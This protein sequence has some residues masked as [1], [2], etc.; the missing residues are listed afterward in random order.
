MKALEILFNSSDDDTKIVEKI[1]TRLSYL[2]I[3][4]PPKIVP[5]MR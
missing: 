5:L 2:V 4:P 1:T 3:P